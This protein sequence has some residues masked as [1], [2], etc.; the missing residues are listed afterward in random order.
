MD[1]SHANIRQ[2]I[3]I[4]IP[5]GRSLRRFVLALRKYPLP[6]VDTVL[7]RRHTF[8]LV[9]STQA[10]SS[11]SKSVLSSNPLLVQRAG[12]KRTMNGYRIPTKDDQARKSSRGWRQGGVKWC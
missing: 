8:P 12:A 9:P 1:E 6:F 11:G 7:P 10:N 2:G 5:C 3:L 4:N